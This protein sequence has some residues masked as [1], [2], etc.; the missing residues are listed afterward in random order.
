MA[1]LRKRTFFNYQQ[2]EEKAGE[3]PAPPPEPQRA[4]QPVT[5]A[6]TPGFLRG[7]ELRT[8]LSADAV[9]T[10]KLSFTAPTRIDGKL[11]GEIRCTDLLVIG[12]TAV[13]EGSVR[14]DVLRIEGSVRGEILD[15]RKVIIRSGGRFVGRIE[16]GGVALEEG[17]YLEAR[18][19]P[20]REDTRERGV[21]GA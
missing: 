19:G 13:V 2:R 9:V 1:I 17:G 14:A 20:I 7:E 4:P 15:T 21:G 16:S 18:C 11:K 8:S 3:K 12:A 6:A 5:P 10:G